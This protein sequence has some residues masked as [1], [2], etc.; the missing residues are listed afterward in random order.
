[1]ASFFRAARARRPCRYRIQNAESFR[2]FLLIA[3]KTGGTSQTAQE[4]G[5]TV[6]HP[7][8]APRNSQPQ[9]DGTLLAFR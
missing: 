6:L 4:F 9:P 5:K 8:P 1:L 2:A 7:L 3:Y